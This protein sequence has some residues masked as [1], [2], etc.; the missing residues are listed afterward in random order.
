MAKSKGVE[1]PK[2]GGRGE[3]PFATDM[4]KCDVCDG[5]GKVSSQKAA[6][7]RRNPT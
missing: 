3:I 2:C 7:W 5:K 6:A 1:C 4:L